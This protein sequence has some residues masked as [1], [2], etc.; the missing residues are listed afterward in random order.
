MMIVEE[1]KKNFRLN[2]LNLAHYITSILWPMLSIIMI[3]YQFLPYGTLELKIEGMNMG[4][5]IFTGI[6]VLI[7]FGNQAM[8]ANK[9]IQEKYLGIMETIVIAPLSNIQYAASRAISNL[10]SNIWILFLYGLVILTIYN[11]DLILVILTILIIAGAAIN[12]GVLLTII[13][14]GVRDP[15]ILFLLIDGPVELVANV[16]I[17]FQFLPNYL[18]ILGT[19]YPQF[20]LLIAI[21]NLLINDSFNGLVAVIVSNL[22]ITLISLIINRYFERYK[23]SW[24]VY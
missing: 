21:R 1:I 8:F 19:L 16:K 18:V 24:S 23:D 17:P 9:I 5:Y 22:V 11:T 2:N 3:I 15:S 12:W 4:F 6:T 13:S 14:M 20:Y 7:I 10:L